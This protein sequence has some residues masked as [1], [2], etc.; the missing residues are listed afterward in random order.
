MEL[1]VVR[2]EFTDD[3]AA[4]AAA[5]REAAGTADVI[6]T[7][8]GVSV[9]AKDILHET[10]PRLNADRVFWQVRL[11]PGSPMMFS[12][13]DGKPLLSLSGNPFAAS[14]TF[15]LFG[16]VLLSVRSGDASLRA[17]VVTAELDTTF[18]KFGR[19]RRFVRSVFRD[20]HVTIPQGHSSGQLASAVGTN[21]L[22]E[23]PPADAP[24]RA[25]ST[26]RVWLL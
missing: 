24:L 7:T 15:E 19:G 18:E 21:C 20:G 2:G 17:Q 11:K 23:I 8:G 3:P 5:I 12:I 22:A 4:L 25:G 9:G 10:L 6:F 14:A 13:Y 16:R 26:V 1:T